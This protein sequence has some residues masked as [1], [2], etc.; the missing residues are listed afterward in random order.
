[1][2][3]GSP[4]YQLA[5]PQQ[6]ITFNLTA[7]AVVPS[8]NPPTAPTITGPNTGV[9]T[10]SYSFTI[11]GSTDPDVGDQIKYQV[12]WNNDGTFNAGD[13]D[14]E[15]GLMASGSSIPLSRSWP[16]IGGKVGLHILSLSIQLQ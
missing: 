16:T 2:L 9:V 12:D 11:G 5:V 3:G 6:T 7:T 1:V 13:G 4:A 10:T 15:T 8:N 14:Y